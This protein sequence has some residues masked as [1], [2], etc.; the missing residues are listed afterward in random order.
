MSVAEDLKQYLIGGGLTT[1]DKIT[2]SRMPANGNISI[3]GNDQWVIVQQPG[4]KTGGNL[5]QWKRIHQL[6]VLYRNSK[7]EVLYDKDDEL[8]TLLEQCV[9]L[10]N[11]KVLRA[12]CGSGG[13]LPLAAK[14]VHVMQWQVTLELTKKLSEES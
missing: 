14:E 6:F 13:E 8:Q 1:A 4:T 11:Y 5:V 10:T 12:I 3:T 2:I 7:G 9:G